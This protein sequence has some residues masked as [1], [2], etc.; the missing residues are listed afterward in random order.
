MTQEERPKQVR[1][2][3]AAIGV[4]LSLLFVGY[5]IRQNT[6]VA[7]AATIQNMADQGIAIALA[8]S[9]DDEASELLGRVND[10]ELPDQFT[11]RER[12]RLRLM[13]LTALRGAEGR[14]RQML[15][16]LVEETD[17]MGGSSALY[18][19]PYLAEQWPQLRPALAADFAAWFETEYQL[20]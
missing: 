3:L 13:Y 14:Y 18:R 16:G 12:A 20:R 9:L 8:W 19:A 5:E 15:L 7:K 2:V 11:E 10:G 1:E 6:R 17:M 4:I